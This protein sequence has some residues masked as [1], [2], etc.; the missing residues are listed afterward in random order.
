LDRE[1]ERFGQ[2]KLLDVVFTVDKDLEEEII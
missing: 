1:Y 2:I